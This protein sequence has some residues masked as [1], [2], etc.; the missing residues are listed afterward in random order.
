MVQASIF[1]EREDWKGAIAL[2]LGFHALLAVAIAII[3]LFTAPHGENW[4]G[5]ESGAAVQ[6]QLV[7]SVPLPAPQQPTEN[8]L[9][10]ENK[11]LTQSVPKPAE[12]QPDAVPIPQNQNKHKMERTPVTP[13][14]DRPLPTTPPRDNVVPYGQ[15][16]QVSGPYGVFNANNMKGGLNFQAGGDFGSRYAWYVQKVNRLITSNWYMVEAGPNAAGHRVYIVF[17]IQPNGT[18][19]NVRIEQTGGVPAL[20]LSALRTIQRIDSFGDTP[21]HDKVSV[22]FWFEVSR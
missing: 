7:S 16:G 4:G 15:G 22:E 14:H 1:E 19:A 18:P 21:T 8:I 11:G 17:D 13:T 6:A 10:T 5:S 20:D 9:A 2:S 12:E 3:G